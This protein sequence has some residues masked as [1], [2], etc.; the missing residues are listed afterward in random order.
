MFHQTA[1]LNQMIFPRNAN[2][3]ERMERFNNPSGKMEQ[4]VSTTHPTTLVHSHTR[5]YIPRDAQSLGKT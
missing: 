2:L 1:H 5:K 3:E 4:V